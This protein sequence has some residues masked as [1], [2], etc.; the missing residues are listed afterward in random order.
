MPADKTMAASGD[1]PDDQRNYCGERARPC[2]LNGD[3]QRHTV[4]RR[5]QL[6]HSITNSSSAPSTSTNDR[7][8]PNTECTP[9]GPAADGLYC[10]SADLLTSVIR[11]SSKLT[12]IHSR[13]C[14]DTA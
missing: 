1:P 8:M 14:A 3:G 10:A 9:A 7:P 4:M 13:W 2:D 11:R 6:H 12:A 5:F